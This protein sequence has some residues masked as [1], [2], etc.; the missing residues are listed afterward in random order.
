VRTNSSKR[1]GGWQ[2]KMSGWKGKG[3]LDLV[4]VVAEPK[5]GGGRKN[6]R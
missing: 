3:W 1:R 6:Q 5:S 4:V 2:R